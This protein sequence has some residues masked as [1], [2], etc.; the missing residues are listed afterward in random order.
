MYGKQNA[1]GWFLLWQFLCRGMWQCISNFLKLFATFD[2]TF[3]L[4]GLDSKKDGTAK[5]TDT[6]PQRYSLQWENGKKTSKQT[7]MPKNR[8]G[9][10]HADSRKQNKNKTKWTNKNLVNQGGKR[11]WNAMSKR[12][13]CIMKWNTAGYI[14]IT[15]HG[16]EQESTG[17]VPRESHTKLIQERATTH[18]ALF[19]KTPHQEHIQ[20]LQKVDYRQETMFLDALLVHKSG[21]YPNYTFTF[22]ICTP[23]LPL[24]WKSRGEENCFPEPSSCGWPGTWLMDANPQP[25]GQAGLQEGVRLVQ[26]VSSAEPPGHCSWS[27]RAGMSQTQPP[28]HERVALGSPVF[29]WQATWA[30]TA[31]T[32]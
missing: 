4:G 31:Q 24:T 2:F 23:P 8:A 5:E 1:Q 25:G 21:L 27:L 29:P 15:Y 14:T 17:C 13:L 16:D 22:A 18:L 11:I 32:S 30:R 10:E 9:W 3:S 12:S 7:Q 26:W 28:G 19:R 6:P 20:C